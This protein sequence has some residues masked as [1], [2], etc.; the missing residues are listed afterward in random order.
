MNYI[1]YNIVIYYRMT[2]INGVEL[3]V[4]KPLKYYVREDIINNEPIEEKLHVIAVV[5]NPCVFLK[6]Y[7]LMKEFIYRMEKEDDV[8]LYIVELAYKDQKFTITE[9]NN[10][11]H[12]QLRTKDPLWHKENMINLGVKYLLP[13]DYKAFAWIDADV[14]FENN[15]WAKDTLKILN[16]SRDIVQV[17]SHC[18]DMDHNELALN[19]F[20]SAGYMYSHNKP[21]SSKGINYWHPGYAWAMTRKAY[22]KIGGLYELGILG[23]GDFLMM[24]SLINMAKKA[25]NPKLNSDYTNSILDFQKKAKNLRFGY[26]P[27]VIK[28]YFHGSKINRK[29]QD[30]YLILIKYS[31]SPYIDVTYDDVGVIVPTEH[32]PE[33]FK[34]DIKSY[35]WERNE[36]E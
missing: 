9:K 8:I 5:S 27:G 13:K 11:R 15:A 25:C 14:E 12:L 10:K 17:F 16:G 19:I 7:K 28:H 18:I 32:F 6:R 29:Y 30:R 31:Y 24:M 36:D 26:V 34:E 4:V 23:S 3:D 33:E 2:V 21:Y 20:N 22:E 35:F 1:I